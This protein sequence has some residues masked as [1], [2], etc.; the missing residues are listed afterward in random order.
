MSGCS[1]PWLDY[2]VRVFRRCEI[3]GF[4]GTTGTDS[5]FSYGFGGA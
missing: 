2:I 4:V 5:I 1:S 3:E